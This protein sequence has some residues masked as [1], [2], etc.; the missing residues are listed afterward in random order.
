MMVVGKRGECG[1]MVLLRLRGKW[2]DEGRGRGGGGGGGSRWD[3]PLSL[4]SFQNRKPE[5][6]ISRVISNSKPRK[7]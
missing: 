5:R 7:K 2:G 3:P 6:N 1:V 4:A